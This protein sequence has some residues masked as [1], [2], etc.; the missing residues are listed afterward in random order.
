[1]RAT[2]NFWKIETIQ[3][4]VATV[5]VNASRRMPGHC[6]SSC[7]CPSGSV[8]TIYSILHKKLGLVKKLAMSLQIWCALRC[9]RVGRQ[10]DLGLQK[11]PFF[12]WSVSGSVF[13]VTQRKESA[14]C[15]Q[16]DLGGSE[17]DLGGGSGISSSKTSSPPSSGGGRSPLKRAFWSAISMRENPSKYIHC[18]F[19]FNFNFLDFC[20]VLKNTS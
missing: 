7:T 2:C 8:N 20:D 6:E 14:L 3:D 11:C 17:D 9:H 13:P 15:H 16:A 5:A 1:M 4:L 19:Q 12:A 10:R 18:Y